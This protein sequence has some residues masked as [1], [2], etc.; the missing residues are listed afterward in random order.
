LVSEALRQK[1]ATPPRW[2]QVKRGVATK[3]KTSSVTQL[4]PKALG[5]SELVPR[6]RW[7]SVPLHSALAYGCHCLCLGCPPVKKNPRP[8]ASIEEVLRITHIPCGQKCEGGASGLPWE[9]SHALRAMI[10]ALDSHGS[11]R[12]RRAWGARPR[13]P[14]PRARPLGL[15]N[16]VKDPAASHYTTPAAGRDPDNIALLF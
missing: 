13:C 12:G 1:P 7:Q 9:Q 8:E 10:P 5:W 4:A 15:L 3:A 6:G 14:T 11:M 16:K 2:R